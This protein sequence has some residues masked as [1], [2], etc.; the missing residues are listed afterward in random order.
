VLLVAAMAVAALPVA[1][2]D[3]PVGN[4]DDDLRNGDSRVALIARRDTG[5]GGYGRVVNASNIN[6][7][8]HAYHHRHCLRTNET[9]TLRRRCRRQRWRRSSRNIQLLFPK[10][11]VT[12]D[13]KNT[14][15]DIC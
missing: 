3:E 13:R 4:N 11:I 15:F 5:D 1:L 12:F 8:Q 10:V 6:T 2:I 7:T 14:F 9:S